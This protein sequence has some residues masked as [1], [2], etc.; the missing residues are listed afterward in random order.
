MSCEKHGRTNNVVCPD[1]DAELVAAY[2]TPSITFLNLTGDITITWDEQNR[3]KVLAMVKKK[4]QEGYTFFTTKRVPILRLTRRAKVTDRNVDLID[5]LIISD[6]EFDAWAK[7][8]DDMDVASAVREG[9]AHLSKRQ[10]RNRELDCVKRLKSA[11]EVVKE[12]AVAV[13]P[14]AGG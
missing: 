10:S 14:I 7:S 8:M 5:S 3:D 6:E 1:C 9:H 13:R 11:D 12:Q 4:M 2:E